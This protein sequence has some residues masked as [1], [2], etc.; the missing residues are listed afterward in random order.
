MI[1]LKK[2]LLAAAL[3]MISGAGFAQS[4]TTKYEPTK[5]NLEARKEFQD[6]KFGIFLH[7]GIYSMTAQGEWY[8]NEGKID[9][10]EYAKLASGF[11]PSKFNAAEWVS[12]IKASG[13]KYI[14]I[15]SRHHDGFSMFGT[16]QSDYNIVD[17]TPF[18]RD[19]LK[20]LAEECKKQGIKLH[21]YYSHLDWRRDDYPEGRTGHFSGRPAGHGDYNSYFNF[22]N[23]QLTELLTNY[24]PIGAIWF[25]GLWD[26]D[27]DSNFNWR[28]DEQY[29]LIHKLQPSCLVG[30]NHHRNPY[31]GE[32]FQMFERDLPGQN[33]T[34]YSKGTDVSQLPLETCETMN[35]MWGYK[36]QDQNYKTTEQL[37]RYLVKAA[38]MNANLLMNIGPQPNGELP[39][40]AV[41]R[42]KEV[43]Q[44]MNS[45]GE[46]IYGTRGGDVAPHDWG[47]STR[48]GDKL[49]IHIIHLKDKA[50]YIP[51]EAKIKSAT[52]FIDKKAISFKAQDGGYLL[53]LPEVPADVDY[54][55][56]LT[57]K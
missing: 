44:W 37:I 18:H 51:L 38:G 9:R 41:Q 29:A 47:V 23:N 39:A 50:L 21:F 10:N 30:N 36:I 22:M 24:G 25:D 46:T 8:M 55:V 6:E 19:V 16:K 33:V 15:T 1:T 27:Q 32:D 5:E 28:L 20:E 11:Y 52:R 48:K 17:A 56:E 34:G 53:Q 4:Y 31:S 14:T 35:G 45:Y 57:L 54:V 3:L 49:Y 26:H 40:V 12:A 43:G 2:H 13:A 7:W 42:M